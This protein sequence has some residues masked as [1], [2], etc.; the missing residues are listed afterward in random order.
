[1]TL[2]EFGRQFEA[3]VQKATLENSINIAKGSVK[4]M[5]EYNRKVGR[6]E[7]LGASVGLMKDMLKQLKSDDD[8]NDLPEMEVTD[9]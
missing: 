1:M 9:D 6:N 5:E 8:R 4:D 3:V 2:D 7:G